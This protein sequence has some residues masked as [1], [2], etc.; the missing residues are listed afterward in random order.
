[1]RNFEEKSY[2]KWIFRSREAVVAERVTEGKA[3][4][5]RPLYALT[6][7]DTSKNPIHGK[8]AKS[9]RSRT[10]RTSA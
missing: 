2:K 8:L 5:S 7:R 1:M 6:V 9:R 4:V 3:H 10:F